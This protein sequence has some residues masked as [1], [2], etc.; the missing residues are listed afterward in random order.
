MSQL[1]GGYQMDCSLVYYKSWKMKRLGILLHINS[2]SFFLTHIQ[3]EYE[4]AAITMAVVCHAV[5]T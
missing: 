5:N 2:H 4:I 3:Y 1:L